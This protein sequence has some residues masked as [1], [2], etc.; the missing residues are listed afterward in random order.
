MHA[1]N[2]HIADGINIPSGKNHDTG[3]DKI[4]RTGDSAVWASDEMKA[5]LI[6]NQFKLINYSDVRKVQSQWHVTNEIKGKSKN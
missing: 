6:A 2:E 3:I 5:F 1:A 4:V